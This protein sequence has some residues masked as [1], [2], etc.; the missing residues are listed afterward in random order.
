MLNYQMLVEKNNPNFGN[1]KMLGSIHIVD[2]VHKTYANKQMVCFGMIY[3]NR[4][5]TIWK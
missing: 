3:S 1:L 4:T 5:K 2:K